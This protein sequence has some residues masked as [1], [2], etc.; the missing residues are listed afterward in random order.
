MPPPGVTLV[1]LELGSGFLGVILCANGSADAGRYNWWG[2]PT[3]R[4]RHYFWLLEMICRSEVSDNDGYVRSAVTQRRPSV[5]EVV[6]QQ[7]CTERR[8]GLIS[9]AAGIMLLSI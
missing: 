3:N 2:N 9:F 1:K 4:R 7:S 6:Q 8:P 5:F